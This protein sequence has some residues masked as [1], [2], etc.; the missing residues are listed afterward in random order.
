MDVISN[1]LPVNFATRQE[2]GRTRIEVT[3]N[4]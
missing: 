4:T 2:A 1:F 3:S